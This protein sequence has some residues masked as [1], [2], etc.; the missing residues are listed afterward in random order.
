[1]RRLRGDRK[2]SLHLLKHVCDSD[3]DWSADHDPHRTIFIV[4][5]H[6]NDAAL[7]IR[8]LH[9]GIATRKWLAKFMIASPNRLLQLATF[10]N[11]AR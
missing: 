6:I 1:M 9:P 10:L 5:T 8:I 11:G 2:L 4:L 3:I 7:E